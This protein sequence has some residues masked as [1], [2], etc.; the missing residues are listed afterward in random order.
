MAYKSSKNINR[1]KNKRFF[2][3]RECST[4]Y[5]N[6]TQREEKHPNWKGGKSSYKKILPRYV[7]KFQCFIC[8]IRDQ[9]VLIV[10][11]IDKN[12][13]NNLPNNL[14][15]LCHSCHFLVHHNKKTINILEEKLKK[16]VKT[17]HKM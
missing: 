4:Q 11:H 8:G 3:S 17:K 2:C 6:S 16:Y 14:M 9:R 7:P 10:H 13:N 1:S 5:L 15:W 12:R